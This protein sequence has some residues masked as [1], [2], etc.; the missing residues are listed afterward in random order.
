MVAERIN[1]PINYLQEEIQVWTLGRAT[2]FKPQSIIF[3]KNL[4]K[5][6]LFYVGLSMYL[7]IY[8]HIMFKKTQLGESRKISVNNHEM[9]LQYVLIYMATRLTPTATG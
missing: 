4:I 2:T 6:L 7:A 5:I 8:S 1:G 9:T 3:M